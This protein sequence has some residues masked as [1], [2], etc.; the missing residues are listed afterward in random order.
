MAYL[1][2][3]SRRDVLR[4][5]AA[6]GLG[7]PCAR[8]VVAEERPAQ[9]GARELEPVPVSPGPRYPAIR[10]TDGVVQPQRP[11]PILEETDVLVVGGGAAGF[12]AAVAA[13][14]AGVRTTLIERYGYF[15]GLWTGGMVLLV[16]GTHAVVQGKLQK[17]LRGIGDELLA[18][19]SKLD[20]AIVNYGEDR[21]NPTVDPEATK[22]VMDE[23][24]TEAGVRVLFH[25]W[26]TDVVM[27]GERPCGVVIDGKSGRQAILAKVLVDAT[28]D[29][30]IFAAAG[31]EHEQRL[32][33][34]GLVH[35]LGNVDRANR[36]RLKSA[37]FGNLGGVTPQP[38][39]TWVNLRG[40]SSN[41]LDVRELTRLEIQHRRAIWERVQALRKQPGGEA[42]FL[43]DTAPQLGVRISRTLVGMKQLTRAEARE[44]R[45]FPDTIGVGG[46]DAGRGPQWPIPYGVLVPKQLDGVLAAGRCVC[47]DEKLIESMRLI[48]ACL[49]TG[50]AAGAAAALCVQDR[51]EPRHVDIG[52]LQS[53]LR[54]QGAYLG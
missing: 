16:M 44:S 30:D 38:S 15:G 6:A 50:H 40:P 18:R 47:V 52:R 54:Q 3:V 21:A 7:A 42:L 31:A 24:V 29:G 34:I 4:V 28:G 43:L 37:G 26:A 20:G 46:A 49:V 25:S 48:A 27:D 51:C 45:T 23:M 13:A 8:W 9:S 41:A 1:R 33:A 36:E 53:L 19:L 12:A 35:R 14:R 22:V 5:M 10:T 11:L 39:V 32:H 2:R 17:T